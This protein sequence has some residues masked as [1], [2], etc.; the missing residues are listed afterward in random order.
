MVE[1]PL[2]ERRNISDYLPLKLIE[3]KTDPTEE[4]FDTLELIENM[5]DRTVR[6]NERMHVLYCRR[7]ELLL[8]YESIKALD[9]RYRKQVTEILHYFNRHRGKEYDFLHDE[10]YDLVRAKLTDQVEKI[11]KSRGANGGSNQLQT[12]KTI[13]I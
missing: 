2:P 6:L 12:S 5:T 11:E 3:M 1:R 4:K 7:Q 13:V 9:I 10:P 8:R